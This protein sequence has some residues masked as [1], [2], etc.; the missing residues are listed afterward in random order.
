M[1]TLAEIIEVAQREID[2]A[3]DYTGDW[4]TSWDDWF[5]RNARYF[6]RVI[7]ELMMM[8]GGTYSGETGLHSLDLGD[9]FVIAEDGYRGLLVAWVAAAR[10]ALAFRQAVPA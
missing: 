5:A 10:D 6:R 4:H 1:R 8:A 7:G 3:P 9:V 2:Y